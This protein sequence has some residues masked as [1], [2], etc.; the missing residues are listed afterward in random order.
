MNWQHPQDYVATQNTTPST[1]VRHSCLPTTWSPL[2]KVVTSSPVSTTIPATSCPAP[3]LR[4]LLP[5]DKMWL[6][7]VGSTLDTDK[8]QAF[9][10]INTPFLPSSGN[11]ICKQNTSAQN[12][13]SDYF[14]L[15]H[16]KEVFVFGRVVY[17]WYIKLENHF[18]F[19]SSKIMLCKANQRR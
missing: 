2:D 19:D 4:F 12:Q 14:H 8:P 15:T 6:N 5:F 16:G 17:R 7:V 10:W 1:F 9:T 3:T 13:E 18:V 11:S